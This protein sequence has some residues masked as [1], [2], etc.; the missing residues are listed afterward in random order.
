M[1]YRC[2]G[3][4]TII[5]ANG[6]YL[7][8]FFCFGMGEMLRDL[9]LSQEVQPNPPNMIEFDFAYNIF[10]NFFDQDFLKFEVMKIGQIR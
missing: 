8:I 1:P 3:I 6:I 10:L 9:R 5:I 7:V 2:Q 4:I